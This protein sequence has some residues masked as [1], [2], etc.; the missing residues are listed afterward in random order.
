MCVKICQKWIIE[1]CFTF[2][3][4]EKNFFIK[5]EKISIFSIS[6]QTG[7]GLVS[8]RPP[9]LKNKSAVAAHGRRLELRDKIMGQ[10]AGQR[11]FLNYWYFLSD[12]ITVDCRLIFTYDVVF[13]M[14]TFMSAPACARFNWKLLFVQLFQKS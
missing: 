5:T 11:Q 8:G 10:R 14:P 12:I 4:L 2:R 1:V 3:H 7:P 9:F 6:A 13:D